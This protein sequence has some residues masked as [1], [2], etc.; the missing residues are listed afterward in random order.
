MSTRKADSYD[1]LR[2]SRHS[3]PVG[4]REAPVWSIPLIPLHWRGGASAP[5]WSQF[6]SS[7]GVARS[8]GVV[9]S[10][11]VEGWREAPG[12]SQF[13]SGGGVARSA[14]VVIPATAKPRV[15]RWRRASDYSPRRLPDVSSVASERGWLRLAGDSGARQ[16]TPRKSERKRACVFAEDNA[17]VD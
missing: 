11:P 2:K 4:C 10:P 14:G 12:W 17:G 13:P 5:G 9:H 7:G 1:A 16:P 6:P 3:P 8:A 15:G